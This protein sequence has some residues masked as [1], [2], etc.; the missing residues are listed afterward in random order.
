V[1][2][3]VAHREAVSPPRARHCGLDGGGAMKSDGR[4]LNDNYDGEDDNDRRRST[5]MRNVVADDNYRGGD[6]NYSSE[7]VVVDGEEQP[8]DN[9]QK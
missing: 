8:G 3:P 7:N 9:R 5:R 4:G 1:I 6:D 2:S